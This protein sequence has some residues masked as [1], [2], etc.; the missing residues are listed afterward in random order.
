MRNSRQ[1]YPAA[2]LAGCA[3]VA[4][5][6][7]A[8]PARAA[9]DPLQPNTLIVSSS[10]YNRTVGAI[11]KLKVGSTLANT[12]TSTSKA[13]AGNSY[14]TTWNNDSVDGSY[15]I[16]SEISLIEINPASGAVQ[17]VVKVPPARW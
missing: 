15:G 10:T 3:A 16:T 11:V 2:L 17:G 8:F 1:S 5:S 4:L 9:S 12:A 7:G 6:A 14:A 13:V